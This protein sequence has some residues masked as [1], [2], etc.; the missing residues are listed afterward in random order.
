MI[1][2]ACSGVVSPRQRLFNRENNGSALIQ[3]KQALGQGDEFERGTL[4][5]PGD[6]AILEDAGDGAASGAAH[7]L[8][9]V[10]DAQRG[11]LPER[12]HGGNHRVTVQHAGDVVGDSG[13]QFAAAHGGEVAEQSKAEFTSDEGKSVSVQEK[14]RSGPV[15][16]A[17]KVE[18]F[19]EGYFFGMDFFPEAL[20]RDSSL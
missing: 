9:A 19:E 3:R 6:A 10:A 8:N 15:E 17:K 5:T 16:I 4:G 20:A 7:C 18:S 12:I 1:P 13:G 11:R 14:E 2:L